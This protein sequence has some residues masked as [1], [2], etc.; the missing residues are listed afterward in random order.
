MPWSRL[1]IVFGD[2]IL[3]DVLD[4]AT[5]RPLGRPLGENDIMSQAAAA[6]DVLHLSAES[7]VYAFD[8]TR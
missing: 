7:G 2:D 1:R 5:G 6:D 3:G 4:R 8:C